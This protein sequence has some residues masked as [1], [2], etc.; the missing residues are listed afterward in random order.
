MKQS[1][2]EFCPFFFLSSLDFDVFRE[3][4]FFGSLWIYLFFIS[5][6]NCEEDQLRENLE[7]NKSFSTK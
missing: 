3:S 6:G 4:I 2:D 5:V 7:G 1:F